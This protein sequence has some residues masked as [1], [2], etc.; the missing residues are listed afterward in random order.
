MIVE[1]L[2]L[3]GLG[4]T[5]KEGSCMDY[6]QFSLIINSI[7]VYNL[8]SFNEVAQSSFHHKI[9]YTIIHSLTFTI[10]IHL[11]HEII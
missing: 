2:G 7:I 3:Y 8:I 9:K 5:S 10:V 11:S 4:L 1:S 6:N